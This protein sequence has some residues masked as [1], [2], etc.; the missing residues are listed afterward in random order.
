SIIGIDKNNTET[1]L[2][3]FSNITSQSLIDLTTIDAKEYPFIKIKT[4]VKNSELRNIPKINYWKIE[5]T[6]VTELT[7]NPIYKNNFHS[8]ILH[9][10]DSL[11]LDLGLSNLS[12]TLSSD[13][14]KISYK[15]IKQDNSF[16]SNSL[17]LPPLD[18]LQSTEFKI[19]ESTLG[20]AGK[21]NLSIT[22]ENMNNGDIYDFN[23]N[24]S[25]EFTVEDDKQEPNI[26]ILFDGKRIVNGEI[27]SATPIIDIASID[28]N[29]FLLQKDT[30]LLDIYLKRENENMF[31][32]INFSDNRLHIIETGSSTNNR[33]VVRYTP[34]KLENGLF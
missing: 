18:V 9:I 21:N 32:R 4:D 20:L 31:K 2:P 25:Y 29:S 5:Y 17:R 26:D 10:G 16:I 34:D 33:M 15:I 27:V 6:P 19:K 23:N 14:I 11:K 24:I 30:S 7:F 3:S 28:E 8:E 22:L 13:S 1:T 12:K